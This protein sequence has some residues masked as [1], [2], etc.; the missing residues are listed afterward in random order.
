[1][2][3]TCIGSRR[4]DASV[5]VAVGIDRDWIAAAGERHTSSAIVYPAA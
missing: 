5:P 2:I 4:K 3:M 1:M